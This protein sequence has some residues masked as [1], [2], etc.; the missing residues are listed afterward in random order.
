VSSSPPEKKT[1]WIKGPWRTRV[2]V[3]RRLCVS[4]ETVDDY[5]D[6]GELAGADM[7][8]KAKPG[9]TRHRRMLRF[10]DDDIDRFEEK[11]R[12]AAAAQ[13]ARNA[14]QASSS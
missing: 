10:L 11:R 4:P 1:V 9:Q 13:R 5:Y 8:P 7:S 2:Q 14:G 12:R 6:V 3:A